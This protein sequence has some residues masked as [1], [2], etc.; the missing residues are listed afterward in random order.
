MK[1]S[2][3][4]DWR[5]ASNYA[6]SSRRQWAWEFLRRNKQYQ[7][8]WK[9][10]IGPNYGSATLNSNWNDQGPRAPGR[11]ARVQI[12]GHPTP[13]EPFRTKFHIASYPPPAPWERK[14]KLKFDSETIPYDRGRTG[15]PYREVSGEIGENEIVMWFNLD[16]PFRQQIANAEKLLKRVGKNTQAR[17]RPGSYREHLRV[18][19]ALAVGKTIKEIATELYPGQPTGIQRVRDHKKAAERLRDRDFWRIVQIEL[20]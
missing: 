8:L 3:L 12:Q 2:W 5:V 6:N 16:W 10:L 7:Q 15:C 19:D 20:F 18:L 17:A 11:R 1:P 13:N 9:R 4:P 14:A